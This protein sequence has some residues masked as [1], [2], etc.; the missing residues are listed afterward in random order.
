MAPFL[1]P[2]PPL[3]T[4]QLPPMGSSGRGGWGRGWSG[5]RPPPTHPKK[6]G[7]T[8]GEANKKKRGPDSSD[9]TGEGVFFSIDL[10]FSLISFDVVVV[11]VVGRDWV[12]GPF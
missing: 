5:E 9:A 3:P 11:V 7:Q 10:Y 4:L 8:K 2:P 1:S 6:S 12:G